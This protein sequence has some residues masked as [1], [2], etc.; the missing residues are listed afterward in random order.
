VLPLPLEASKGPVPTPDVTLSRPAPAT[1]PG[2]LRT[3]ELLPPLLFLRFSTGISVSVTRM[4]SES[5][6]SD[7][8]VVAAARRWEVSSGAGD[9]GVVVRLAPL[10]LTLAGRRDEVG[11]SEQ[12]LCSGWAW[13][14]Q[15]NPS[16]A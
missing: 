14:A 10:P 11:G 6:K 15:R 4:G 13:G 2:V 12:R 3:L 9:E 7:F 16:S 1:A 8:V 5:W